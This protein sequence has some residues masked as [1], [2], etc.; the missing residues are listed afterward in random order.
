VIAI[1]PAEAGTGK[2]GHFGFFRSRMRQTLW[3]RVIDWLR[4]SDAAGDAGA[5]AHAAD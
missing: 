4:E 3:A 1:A 2:I 5:H